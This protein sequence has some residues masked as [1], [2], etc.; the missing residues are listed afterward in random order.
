MELRRSKRKFEE[1][2]DKSRCSSGS[3]RE[4]GGVVG[5]RV[6]W[7]ENNRTRAFEV[8]NPDDE[9]VRELMQDYHL[10]RQEVLAFLWGHDSN[11]V[12]IPSRVI[13]YWALR[14]LKDYATSIPETKKEV[15]SEYARS[16]RELFTDEDEDDEDEDDEDED[17]EDRVFS[18]TILIAHAQLM[19]RTPTTN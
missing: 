13:D 3:I 7:G 12:P 10:D 4:V 16:N 2:D 18:G 5:N 15:L 8:S 1:I 6:F 11:V 17:D 9:V 19:Y 14:K